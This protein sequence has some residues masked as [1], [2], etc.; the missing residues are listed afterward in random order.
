MAPHAM[1]KTSAIIKQFKIQ[2]TRVIF[3]TLWIDEEGRLLFHESQEF[4]KRNSPVLAVQKLLI[5]TTS[6]L[7]RF[8]FPE[9]TL[10][11]Q[12]PFAG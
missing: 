1:P 4:G 2:A 12:V 8:L 9:V 5:Q 10:L 7:R 3:F 11:A 6:S